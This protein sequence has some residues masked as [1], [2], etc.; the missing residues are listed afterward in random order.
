M[1]CCPPT[2][3]EMPS[4][5]PP[6]CQ[7]SLAHSYLSLENT[8]PRSGNSCKL[9]AKPTPRRAGEDIPTARSPLR[10]ARITRNSHGIAGRRAPPAYRGALVVAKVVRGINDCVCACTR[11]QVGE[12]LSNRVARCVVF[13]VHGRGNGGW[14]RSATGSL[15]RILY[16]N[17]REFLFHALG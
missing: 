11:P 7:V 6:T 10:A 15:C 8:T 2:C 4:E 16:T 9:S 3:I 14:S 1:F 12:Y 5:M 13:P 17:F